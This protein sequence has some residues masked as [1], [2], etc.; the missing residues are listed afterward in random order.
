LNFFLPHTETICMDQDQPTSEFALH[1]MLSMLWSMEL[2]KE[3][4]GQL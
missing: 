1:M 2:E 3:S 4:E